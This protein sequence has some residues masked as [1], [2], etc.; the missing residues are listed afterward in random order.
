MKRNAQLQELSRKIA[1]YTPSEGVAR[2][3]AQWMLEERI[4][5][6][7]TPERKSK[8]GDYRSPRSGRN[9]Q[10]SINGTLNPYAFTITFVHEVAH[11]HTWVKYRNRVDPHGVEWK[12]EFQRLMKD[13]FL[14]KGAVFPE[15]IRQP[16][17][18]YMQNPAA[19]TGRD[20]VL[21]RA[22]RAYDPEKDEEWAYLSDLPTGSWFEDEGG[23]RFRKM[24][25]LRKNYRCEEYRTGRL[26]NVSPHVWV[27]SIEPP[28]D[29][30]PEARRAEQEE[31]R[32]KALQ[33]N[34]LVALEDIPMGR[35]FEDHRGVRFMKVKK[36]R[37]NYL[38]Q[39]L[40]SGSS[41]RIGPK[42]PARPLQAL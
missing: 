1:I 13:P 36:L 2:L 33:S 35:I 5:L 3:F 37:K 17:E 26:F 38:C 22:L 11:L 40:S 10:I 4:H 32:E 25:L 14:K 23:R 41:Y 24:H 8:L 15:D 42:Y 16:L 28:K 30:N 21:Y 6:R 39:E 19:A 12:R 18:G 34:G 27:R 29:H 31:L 20:P 7:I 9:H